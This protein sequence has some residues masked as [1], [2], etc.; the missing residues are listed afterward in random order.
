MRVSVPDCV[1]GCQLEPF[2]LDGERLVV[3]CPAEDP[4]FEGYIEVAED[5]ANFVRAVPERIAELLAECNGLRPAPDAGVERA[6]FCGWKPFR[7]RRAFVYLAGD[8]TPTLLYE[9]KGNVPQRRNVHA[10]ICHGCEVDDV[11]QRIAGELGYA[12]YR[13]PSQDEWDFR[14]DLIPVYDQLDPGYLR[15]RYDNRDFL[16]EEVTIELAEGMRQHVVK[17]NGLVHKAFAKSDLRFARLLLLAAH[18]AID[19]DVYYGGWAYRDDDLDLDVKG[20]D[21]ADLVGAFSRPGAC[22]GCG[23]S[24]DNLRLLVRSNPERDGTVRLAV[25][26]AKIDIDPALLQAFKPVNNPRT[27][28]AGRHRAGHNDNIKTANERATDLVR[29]AFELL[30]LE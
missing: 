20:D 17:V 30:D 9:I 16:F 3:E 24:E 5:D 29:R 25:D 13:L 7:E 28:K 23:L 26:P 1:H 8:V 22:A 10:V 2:K 19:S 27:G 6:W 18:R 11:T 4:C 15:G 12:L 14:L 21:L